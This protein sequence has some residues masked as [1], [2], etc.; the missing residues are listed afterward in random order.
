MIID[1]TAIEQAFAHLIERARQGEEGVGLLAEDTRRPVR[2]VH[3]ATRDRSVMTNVAATRWVPLRNVAEFP[4]L[5]YEVDPAE[6]LD[7][8]Q[9]LEDGHHVPVILVHSHLTGGGLPSPTDVR[10]ATNPALL[11]MIVDLAGPRPAPYLWHLSTDGETA[12][13]RFQVADLRQRGNSATDLTRGVT[14]A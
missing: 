3:Q 8:Y 2:Y 14:R 6:L 10:Y 5:R 7:A 12:K 9:Q 11:H 13:I 1:K 4:R